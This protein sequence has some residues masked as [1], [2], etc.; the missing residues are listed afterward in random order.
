MKV[1]TFNIRKAIILT[2]IFS[3]VLAA[4]TIIAL[5]L[6]FSGKAFAESDIH[7]LPVMSMTEQRT[8][9]IDAGHGGEDCGAIGI[10]GRYEKDLNLEISLILGQILSDNGFAVVYTRTDD[11]L[12]YTDAEN[13]K[14]IR[15]I[16]DLKNRCKVGAEHPE[17]IFVSIHMNSY[18]DARYSGLHAYYSERSEASETLANSIQNTVK[19]DLQPQNNRVPKPGKNMYLM[20]NLENTAILIECGFITNRE[21][22]EKLCEKEYQ[23]QLSFAIFCGIIE[24]INANVSTQG[25]R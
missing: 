25:D 17:A 21:E 8:V 15:K 13:I 10:N 23:K 6:Y 19:K 4:F 20:E 7:V 16:S 1:V 12:L 18:G 22:C 9:I 3:K 5:C 2:R 14:G 11:K 24:Y